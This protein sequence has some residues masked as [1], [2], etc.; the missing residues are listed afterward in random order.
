MGGALA[1]FP[2]MSGGIG[3]AKVCASAA[4]HGYWWPQTFV[5]TAFEGGDGR[6]TRAFGRRTM[7]GRVA[8]ASELDERVDSI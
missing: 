7:K 3:S 1:S 8:N 2:T 4:R 6:G 5:E